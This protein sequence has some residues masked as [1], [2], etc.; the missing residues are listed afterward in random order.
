[1]LDLP[2]PGFELNADPQQLQQV[3]L[4]LVINAIESQPTGGQIGI[5]LCETQ[6]PDRL[7]EVEIQVTDRGTGIPTEIL[8]RIFDPFFSTKEAGT[9]IG[10]AICQR[11]IE[12]HSGTIVP[13][14]R[15]Q[16]GAVFTI[17]LP[18]LHQDTPATNP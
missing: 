7:R 14:N 3:M 9:G 8:E 10:L 18:T 11:I 13:Q 4:N 5:H 17:R 15:S 12:D 2:Q 16:G 1:M 6:A